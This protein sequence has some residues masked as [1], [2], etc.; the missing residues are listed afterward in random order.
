MMNTAYFPPYFFVKIVKDPFDSVNVL[1]NSDSTGTPQFFNFF[2][3]N[4]FSSSAIIITGVLS[5]Y[6]DDMVSITCL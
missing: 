1:W 3:S 2:V 5:T 6:Y 4:Y